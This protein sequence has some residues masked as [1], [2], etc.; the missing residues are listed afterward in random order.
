MFIIFLRYAGNIPAPSEDSA[1]SSRHNSRVIPSEIL[2]F[3][4]FAKRGENRTEKFPLL[5]RGTKGDLS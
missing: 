5:K 4:S 2:P 1:R 3:P